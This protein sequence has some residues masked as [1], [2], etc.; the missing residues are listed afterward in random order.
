M[1]ILAT[2]A[3][4]RSRGRPAIGINIPANKNLLEGVATADELVS[5]SHRFQA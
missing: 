3:F 4:R 5:R 1:R 2:G